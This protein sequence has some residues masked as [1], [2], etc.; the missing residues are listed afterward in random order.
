M[1]RIGKVKRNERIGRK[2]S[3]RRK[4]RRRW[5]SGGADP[6][7]AGSWL[8]SSISL[9]KSKKHKTAAVTSQ[10]GTYGIISEA[11]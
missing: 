2:R 7:T 4:R 6:D 3:A 9:Q 5:V 1:A 8:K 11:E 10:W